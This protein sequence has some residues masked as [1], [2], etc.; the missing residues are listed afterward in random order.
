MLHH[1]DLAPE[2][3][4]ND[5]YAL[6]MEGDV[7]ILE[8]VEPPPL[9]IKKPKHYKLRYQNDHIILSILC[10]ALILAQ[11]HENPLHLGEKN[12]DGH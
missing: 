8:A 10:Y 6:A 12:K 7:V 3:M 2:V 11:T 1:E 5:G 9:A 4:E